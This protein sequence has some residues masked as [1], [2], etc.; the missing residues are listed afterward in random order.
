MNAPPPPAELEP[1]ASRIGAA[2]TLALIEAHGGCRVFVARQPNQGSEL[3]RDIGLPAARALAER[4]GGE[5]LIVPL[6]R[7][8]RVRLYRLRGDTHREIARRLGIT[9]KQVQKL[10]HNAGLTRPPQR[11]LFDASA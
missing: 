10:L 9:E 8:W 6:A 11:D 1:I 7:A 3:A 2:A 5:W 4:W